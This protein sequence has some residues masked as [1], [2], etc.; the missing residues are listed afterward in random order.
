MPPA[1]CCLLFLGCLV[2]FS[3]SLIDLLVAR[4]CVLVIRRK[5]SRT[6]YLA[7][8]VPP[9][10]HLAPNCRSRKVTN[11]S[12]VPKANKS[13]IPKVYNSRNRTNHNSGSPKV[14]KP[15]SQQ[16]PKEEDGDQNLKNK[17]NKLGYCKFRTRPFMTTKTGKTMFSL[18]LSHRILCTVCVFSY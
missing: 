6:C 5:P 11:S 8:M 9:L 15:Q 12:E 13:Q 17:N 18:Q 4:E 16:Y 3:I 14:A 1:H 7:G 2:R 10:W